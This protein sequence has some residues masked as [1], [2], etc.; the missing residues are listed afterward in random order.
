MY[1]G[2]DNLGMV[3]EFYSHAL[4]EDVE[5]AFPQAIVAV[6]F[7]VFHDAA[8]HLIDLLEPT[9]LHKR[10]QD[11]TAYA[12]GTVGNHFLAFQVVVF[13]AFQ[14]SYKVFAGTS[15]WDDRV[16]ELTY[17]RFVSIATV[18]EHD[19]VAIFFYQFVYLLRLEVRT[20]AD[21]AFDVY[22]E[23]IGSTE[24]DDF[25]TDLHLQLREMVAAAITPFE[26]CVGEVLL[27]FFDVL[28]QIVHIAADRAIDAVLG[29]KDTTFE[30]QLF[31]KCA[32]P[33]PDR[34]RVGYRLEFVIQNDFLHLDSIKQWWYSC[35][36]SLHK[37]TMTTQLSHP[38]RSASLLFQNQTGSVSQQQ[39]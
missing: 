26:L 8:V 15:I 28:L 5:R 9:V 24:A 6:F 20:A 34:F 25:I 13:A 10:R 11:F 23:F 17:G 3:T 21:D 7:A 31:A 22:L 1:A 36:L 16:F 12:A 4:I 29:D 32:L 27:G 30:V 39:I 33:Q 37:G 38:T 18:E 35:K 19:V 14:L 2:A